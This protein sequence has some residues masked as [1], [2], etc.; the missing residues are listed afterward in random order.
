VSDLRTDVQTQI[1]ASV[2]LEIR[3]L[4]NHNE[5]QANIMVRTLM[6]AYEYARLCVLMS[7]A[8]IHKES[9]KLHD[10]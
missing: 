9:W 6:S 5:L 3:I 8:L 1:D 7:M 10:N 2:F 4:V